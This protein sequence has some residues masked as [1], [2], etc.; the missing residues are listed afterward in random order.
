MQ[1]ACLKFPNTV[2]EW[3]LISEKYSQ[4]WTFPNMIGAV[5]GKHDILQQPC[6]SASHYRNHKGT[7]SIIFMAVVGPEYQFLFADVGMSGRNSDGG[8]WLQSPMRKALGKNTL[9]LSKPKSL[10]ENRKETPF[11]C[12]GDDAFR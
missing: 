4:R 12:V 8:N 7:D 5:D 9:S 3:F 2:E 6:N 10:H 11:V 1:D